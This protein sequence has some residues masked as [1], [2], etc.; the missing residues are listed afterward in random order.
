MRLEPFSKDLRV[1]PKGLK[2]HRRPLVLHGC[3]RNTICS[4]GSTCSVKRRS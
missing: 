2:A 4:A 1:R 3:S